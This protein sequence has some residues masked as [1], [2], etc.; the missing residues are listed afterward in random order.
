MR[1]M[2]SPIRHEAPPRRAVVA[3]GGNALTAEGQEGTAEQ[4]AANAVELAGPLAGLV[5]QGWQVAV[6]HGNGPQVGSLSLQ[7]D[8]AADEVPVQPLHQLCAMTQGQLGSVLACAVDAQC[9]A[10]TAVALVTHV[11]V[12]PLDPAFASPTKPIGPFL[13]A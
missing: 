4:I 2:P 11:L 1:Y 7:Q 6:V 5:G 10:G 13:T 12:D 9:G 8:A 3:V